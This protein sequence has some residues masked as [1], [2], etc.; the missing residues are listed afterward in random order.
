MTSLLRA[1]VLTLIVTSS[2]TAGQVQATYSTNERF[3]YCTTNIDYEEDFNVY[4]ENLR[5]CLARLHG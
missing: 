2:A 3:Y 1:L 4:T 5:R